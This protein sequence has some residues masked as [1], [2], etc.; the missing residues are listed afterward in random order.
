MS[1]AAIGVATTLQNRVVGA[2]GSAQ[3][4]LPAPE[5]NSALLQAGATGIA[6]NV[7]DQLKKGQEKLTELTENIG[8]VLQEQL[9]IA[10][11]QQR[12]ERDRS[13]EL[14]PG[15]SVI[16]PGQIDLNNQAGE[17]LE[18]GGFNLGNLLS[19]G[20]GT[21]FGAG[22]VLTAGAA[23]RFA[24]GL[25]KSLLRGGFYAT[26]A[27]FLT[28]PIIDFV[29]EGILKF[30]IPETEE[31]KIEDAVLG[32]VVFGSIF[33]PK[34]AVLALLGLGLKNVYDTLS[35]PEKGLKDLSPTDILT[36]AIGTLGTGIFFSSTIKKGLKAVGFN[37][38]RLATIG[39]LIAAPPFIIAGGLAI[40][41]G[42]GA[43][44][45]AEKVNDM[46]DQTLDHLNK[47]LTMTQDEFEMQ[48]KNQEASFL[49][50]NARGLKLLFSGPE[51]LTQGGQNVVA[52]K[53]A[54]DD[55]KF[56]GG[57]VSAEDKPV[58]I[59]MAEKYSRLSQKDL[60]D[61]MMDK[62]GLED[63]LTVSENL[64]AIAVRGG[65]GEDSKQVAIDMLKLGDKIKR[66]AGTL[67]DR[68]ITKGHLKQQLERVDA[69][70]L[71]IT[72]QQGSVD[73]LEKLGTADQSLLTL[74]TQLKAA[75]AALMEARVNVKK[76]EDNKGQ[77]NSLAELRDANSAFRKA[78][79]LVNNIESEIQ[80][81]ETRKKFLFT[82]MDIQYADLEKLFSPEELKALIKSSMM[83]GSQQIDA[84]MREFRNIE[85]NPH[86]INAPVK[87]DVKNVNNAGDNVYVNG[88]SNH[89]LDGHLPIHPAVTR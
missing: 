13:G 5:L 19:A 4:L 39:G 75:Q 76:A 10:K 21:I 77:P 7:L 36:T 55:V 40:A 25:G 33:G 45:L 71:S 20:L 60:M 6:T 83:T 26:M 11:E 35:D 44:L 42:A 23:L 59:D 78:L 79:A 24:K 66:A 54:L 50:R 48:L 87:T 84:A 86:L 80:Q 72:S 31:K 73:I 57:Q 74:D 12:R 14:K 9:D 70:D 51:A 61:I 53:A 8:T 88:Q 43:Y 62:Q 38:A 69:G 27:T 2:L 37:T 22:G 67:L 28:K 34:G 47:L 56:E 30:D 64:R 15:T 29:E 52:S 58:I 89:N 49:E 63:L 16:Q 3:N 1:A 85:A 82:Q 32:S 17:A 46:E 68:N 18:K 81:V 41:A 65:L